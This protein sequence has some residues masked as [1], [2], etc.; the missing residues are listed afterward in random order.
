MIIEID[1]RKIR[2]EGDVTVRY[3]D[4]KVEMFIAE[5]IDTLYLNKDAIKSFNSSLKTE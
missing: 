5:K 2:A 4:D 1:G 3:I